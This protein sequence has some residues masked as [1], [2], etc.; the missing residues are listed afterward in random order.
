MYNLNKSLNFLAFLV[1]ERQSK[2]CLFAARDT[3]QCKIILQCNNLCNKNTDVLGLISQLSQDLLS[4]IF[5]H[6]NPVT[7]EI[8]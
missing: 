3:R 4:H 6:R 7:H 2:E 8:I 5:I 1:L